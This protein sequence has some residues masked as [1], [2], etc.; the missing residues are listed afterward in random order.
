MASIPQSSLFRWEE[1][2]ELGDLARFVLV[3][4][5]LPDEGLM[6]TLERERGKGRNDYPVRAI[7]N[8]ILAGVVFGHES[9]ESLRRELGRNAQLRQVCGFDPLRGEGAVP[10]AWVYSRFLRCLFDHQ[11]A[12]DVML[13]ELVE[14]LRDELD[15][16]GS[17]LAPFPPTASAR[18]TS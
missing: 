10:P 17:V 4:E 18:R 8:S 16:F 15:G 3:R 11:D 14:S 13:D 12:I 2:E 9:I 7:W 5:T 6:R 1:V